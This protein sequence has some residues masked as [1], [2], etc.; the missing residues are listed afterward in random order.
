MSIPMFSLKERKHRNTFDRKSALP[1]AL[2]LSKGGPRQTYLVN[3]L[4]WYH[5]HRMTLA[6]V[7]AM[8]PTPHAG[9]RASAA[10][11]RRP[12]ACGYSPAACALCAHSSAHRRASFQLL[13]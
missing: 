2:S 9:V 8:S 4:I 10:T 6:D 7:P 5:P 1:L 11:L 13:E 12:P 3:Y